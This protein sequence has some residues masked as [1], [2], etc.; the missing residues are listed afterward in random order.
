MARLAGV[1]L[2]KNKKVYF[3]L[4]YIFG[5]GPKIS[6]LIL[7][8]SGVNPDKKFQNLLKLKLQKFVQ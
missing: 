3:G 4:Q 7:E 5:V 1:D 6:K 8:K 2:P